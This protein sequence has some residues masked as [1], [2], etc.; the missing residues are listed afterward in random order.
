MPLPLQVLRGFQGPIGWEESACKGEIVVLFKVNS[1]SIFQQNSSGWLGIPGEEKPPRNLFQ[2]VEV[3]FSNGKSDCLVQ[4]DKAQGRIELKWRLN[5]A[6]LFC[7]SC[8]LFSKLILG[9]CELRNRHQIETYL[10]IV[11]VL[12]SVKDMSYC[13]KEGLFEETLGL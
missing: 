6:L 10:G 7:A 4:R 9:A 13:G 8:P 11:P 1:L 3:A 2:F 12:S 5:K